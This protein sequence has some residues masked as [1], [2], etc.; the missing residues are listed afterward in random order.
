MVFLGLDTGVDHV[1]G[2]T[3]QGAEMGMDSS[4]MRGLSVVVI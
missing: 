2:M 1:V 3:T 4:L